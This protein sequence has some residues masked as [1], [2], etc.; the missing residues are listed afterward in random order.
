MSYIPLPKETFS[1]AVPT[2]SSEHRYVH[3]GEVFRYTDAVTINSGSSQD[4]LLTTPVT[5]YAHL[6]LNADGAAITS[7]FF[8]EAT[9]RIGTTLQ[10]TYNANRNSATAAGMTIKKG[11][12]GGTTDGTQLMTYSSGT[13]Q[14][15]SRSPAALDYASEWV[16]K[17]STKYIIRITSGTASNLCN[18]MLEWYEHVSGT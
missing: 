14:G 3:M 9:D 18:I 1:Q 2:I 13:A 5:P 12:S 11:T 4:Y 16:L 15:N 7:F 6:K 17:P 8:F 10:S